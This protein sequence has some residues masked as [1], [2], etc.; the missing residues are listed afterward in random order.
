MEDRISRKNV[1]RI[2]RQLN[3]YKLD[4]HMLPNGKIVYVNAGNIKKLCYR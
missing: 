1:K 3:K 2:K 4:P